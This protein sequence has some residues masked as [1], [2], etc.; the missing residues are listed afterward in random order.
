MIKAV[1]FDLDGVLVEAVDMHQKAFLQ[2]VKPYKEITEEEH[3]RY[4][5][6]IPTKK[7]LEK[8]G[9]NTDLIE[10][11]YH[12]KEEITMDLIPKMIFP[13]Q[14]VHETLAELKLRGIPFCVCTN[15]IRK[16]AEMMLEAAEINDFD[17]IISNQEVINPKPHP[18]MYLKAMERFGLEPSEVVI[19]EDAPVGLQAARASGANVCQI[20]DSSEISL[21]LEYLQNDNIYTSRT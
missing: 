18:E 10:K 5:N 8:L 19:V 3:M 2:A 9:F 6:G 14:E 13:I 12:K 11:I 20:K 1:L 7:K 4:L 17:F 15:S 21:V 16:T